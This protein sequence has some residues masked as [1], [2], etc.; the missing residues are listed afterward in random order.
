MAEPVSHAKR[1]VDR[2]RNGVSSLTTDEIAEETPVA[3]VYNGISHAVM[4]ATP[5]G[6]EQFG[7][8]F[9]LAE[10]ILQ[11]PQ[12]LYDMEIVPQKDGIELQ[13]LI[14][15]E[16]FAN[17]KQ[18]RRNLAG[19][20]GCG[21]C[22]AESLQQVMRTP[23]PVGAGVHI[24]PEVLH[25]AFAQLPSM[26]QLQTLTGAVHAAAWALPDGSLLH[27]EEDIGRHNALDKLIGTMA[28]AKTPY[29]AGFAI[30]TSR[31]SFEMVQKSAAV[32]IPF[33][34]AISA[35]TGLAIELA[36]QAGITL[37]GFARGGGHV[38]YTHSKRFIDHQVQL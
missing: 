29:N 9:S 17:L 27:L 22:G 3:M 23:K 5:I 11:H 31:A 14:S 13:M 19:R 26:Q 25:L 16:R 32:G 36:A 28:K 34:A 35:P 30:I 7:L 10:G 18:L 15:Q 1:A 12:E 37:V 2:W 33:L 24:S 8:G 21:L 4:L 38:I 20:T 6:L